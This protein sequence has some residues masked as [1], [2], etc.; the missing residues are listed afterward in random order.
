MVFVVDVVDV[1]VGI[2]VV[3]VLLVEFVVVG[4]FAVAVVASAVCVRAT[5]TCVIGNT[6]DWRPMLLP[7]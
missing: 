4:I 6:A 5:F 7:S 3:V 1:G 2:F